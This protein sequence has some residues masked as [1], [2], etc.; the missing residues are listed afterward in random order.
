MS[1]LKVDA[2]IQ[3][4]TVRFSLVLALLF[5]SPSLAS[6]Q[7][8]GQDRLVRDIREGR[9]QSNVPMGSMGS[10]L[11]Q[12]PIGA[13]GMPRGYHVNGNGILVSPDDYGREV[14]PQPPT[15]AEPDLSNGDKKKI[16]AEYLQYEERADNEA[17]KLPGT[18]KKQHLRNSY[19]IALTSLREK[20]NLTQLE[21]QWIVNHGSEIEKGTT[22]R[23]E[24]DS[25]SQETK[26]PDAAAPP[27]RPTAKKGSEKLLV[28]PLSEDKSKRQASKPVMAIRILSDAEE[29]KIFKNWTTARAEAWK[30]IR[31]SGLPEDQQNNLLKEQDSKL[32]QD[33]AGK[34][35][36]R[37]DQINKIRSKGIANRWK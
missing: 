24:T 2:Q 26:T 31:S 29:Q 16:Y 6:A 4:L 15:E 10:K 37:L 3:R 30:A 8:Y 23:R 22:G 5:L 1:T 12:S 33:L 34:Y 35:G 13:N 7:L 27:S 36:V 19:R 9:I 32:A 21:I 20:Y 14:L 17:K 28:H 25:L 11:F 18:R